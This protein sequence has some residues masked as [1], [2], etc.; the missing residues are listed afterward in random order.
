MPCFALTGPRA[1]SDAASIPDTGIICKGQW[2]G[3]ETIGIRL[4]FSKRYITLAPI[5]TVIGLAFRLYDPEHL[6]G[7]KAD[8]GI[9]CA[10][11]PRDTPGVT[12]GRRHFPLEHPVPKWPHPGT[13]RV[14]A[15]GRHHRRLCHGRAGLAHAGGAI[16]RGPLHFAAL[17]RHRRRAGRRL[18]IGRLRAYPPPIQHA[19]RQLRGHRTGSG[20]H[21]GAHLHH[22]CRALRDRRRHRRRRKAVGALRHAQ[23]SR[24]RNRP[25]DRQR[26][27]G[28]AWRQGH[29]AGAEQLSRARLPDRAGRHHR[30][31][32]QYPDAQ[33]DHLRSGGGALSSLSC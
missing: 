16:V 21:G 6:M 1:G 14:R 4:N 30:R 10:L 28:C 24:H 17:E 22:R 18:C 32:R 15:D 9:T 19:D 25:H 11:I 8:L 7:E 26:C 2:A 3:R 23:I 20:A 31:G 5:A 29:H 27:H 33:L 12:I 13:R